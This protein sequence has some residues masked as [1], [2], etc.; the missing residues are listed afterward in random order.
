MREAAR[1]IRTA[2]IDVGGDHRG[3]LAA[4]RRVRGARR[5]DRAEECPDA[6]RHPVARARPHRSAG[7]RERD[8]AE[9]RAHRIWR[10]A[11]P[12]AFTDALRGQRY[13]RAALSDAERRHGD[14]GGDR[15]ARFPVYSFA[16]GPTNSMRGAAFLSGL[17]RRD[18][19]RCRRHDHRRRQPAPRLP[20][21]GQQ[22]GRGRRRAH[23][24]PHAGPAVDRSRRRH[25]GRADD[26]SRSGRA[27]S[28][29]GCS[30]RA[31]RLRRR[32]ADGDRRRRRRRP[33]RPRRPRGGWPICRALRHRQCWRACTRCSTR[34]STG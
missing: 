30:K 3:V 16:S 13:R 1:R 21:R 9:R 31:L 10:G 34:R 18:G 28:A 8:A 22:R 23:P 33:A 24:V 12:Q 26:G 17:E 6:R 11:R 25:S 15:R 4:E 29:T 20:A 14:A 7:A 19:R 2:G 5:P 27:A 32:H